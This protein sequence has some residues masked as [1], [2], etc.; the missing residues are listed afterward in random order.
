MIAVC[1][2]VHLI[3]S[4]FAAAEVVVSRSF[5]GA[6]LVIRQSFFQHIVKMQY[7]PWYLDSH[8]V[9]EQSLSHSDAVLPHLR[10]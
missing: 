7:M 5:T 6:L 2:I 8:C 1:D 4:P 3:S 9:P 10:P